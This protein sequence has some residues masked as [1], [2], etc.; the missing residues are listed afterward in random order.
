M[1]DTPTIY[2]FDSKGNCRVWRMEIDG[3]RYRTISGIE[4]GNLTESKWTT[5]KPKNVGR[6]NETS[7]EEQAQAEVASKYEHK[8]AREYHTTKESAKSGAHFF[9]PMLAQEYKGL[10]LWQDLYAQ[11]KLDGM[12]CIA[13]KDG[14]FSRQGKPILGCPHIFEALQPAFKKDPTLILDG[15]LYNHDLKDDFPKL[16]SLCKKKDPSEEELEESAKMVQYHVYDCPS[17]G[18]F[19]FSTRMVF[20]GQA[21]G[22]L[23]QKLDGDFPIWKVTTLTIGSVEQFNEFHGKCVEAGYEGSMLRLDKPYEQKRSKYLLKRKDFIDAEFPVLRMVEGEGNWSG[24]IKSV[25][26]RAANNKEFGAGVKGTRE[27]AEGLMGRDF[28]YA[29]VRYFE[30]TPD[31]VPRFGICLEL[32]EGE[33]DD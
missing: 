21:M 1:T 23:G 2:K 31:G 4:D 32:Y 13:T 3:A 10:P 14:L 9:K 16:M 12:R 33:R 15:E 30:L 25:V 11:P 8:L 26:C 17:K 27:Y 29:K 7:A 22:D 28:A 6:A 20:L 5:A 19:K 24:A 18:S